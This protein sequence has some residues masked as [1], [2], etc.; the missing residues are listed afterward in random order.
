LEIKASGAAMELKV[1]THTPALL[2]NCNQLL[3]AEGHYLIKQVGN[4]MVERKVHNGGYL[5]RPPTY[6]PAIG[7]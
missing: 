7:K 1:I 2:Q 5:W 6:D 4:S 3:G